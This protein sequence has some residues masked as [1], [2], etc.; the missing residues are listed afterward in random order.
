MS[1]VVARILS[2]TKFF[3]FFDFMALT[4]PM[5]GGEKRVFVDG[6]VDGWVGGW[7]DE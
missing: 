1:L 3:S 4:H 6:R 5:D 2:E 7:I